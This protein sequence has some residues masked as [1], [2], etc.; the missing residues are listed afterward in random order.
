MNIELQKFNSLVSLIQ[1]NGIK[2][3]TPPYIENATMVAY[4]LNNVK[5][6]QIKEYKSIA[7]GDTNGF[8]FYINVQTKSSKKV[9]RD[10]FLRSNSCRIINT[11]D[12]HGI[13]LLGEMFILYKKV[14]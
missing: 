13:D 12:G 3:V 10:G 7:E 4:R 6:E 14:R 9:S 1:E 2:S 8:E 11:Q 5:S